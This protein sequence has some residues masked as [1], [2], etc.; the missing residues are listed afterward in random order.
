MK[1]FIGLL[2]VALQLALFASSTS[3]LADGPKLKLK[4]PRS[5]FMRPRMPNQPPPRVTIRITAE[6]TDLDDVENLEEYYCLDEVW[7]WDDDTE[8]KYGPDCDPYEEG[9]EL[10]RR[11]GASHQ[12]S[13][14]GTYTIWLRL[15]RNGE[16]VIAGN[17]KVMIRS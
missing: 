7:D 8:S 16:T 2:L 9:M 4:G 15:Q 13:V 14:P 12:F 11:F 10:T 6:L 17:A 3:V 1:K 5:T